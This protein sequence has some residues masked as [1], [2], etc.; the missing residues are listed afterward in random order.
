MSGKLT[1]AQRAILERLGRGD[2]LLSS[3]GRGAN[4]GF[5]GDKALHPASVHA[6][7]KAGLTTQ[8][9]TGAALTVG[10]YRIDLTALGRTAIKQESEM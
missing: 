5:V 8:I 9:K 6:L 7:Y 1:K 4:V 2:V 10:L 3:S